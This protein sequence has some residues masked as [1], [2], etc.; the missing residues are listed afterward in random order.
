MPTN[1]VHTIKREAE[2]RR[3]RRRISSAEKR[4][5]LWFQKNRCIICGHNF[6]KSVWFKKGG[7]FRPITL[8]FDHFIPVSFCQNTETRNLYALCSLC[9]QIKW[10]YM[11]DTVIDARKYIMSVRE[12]RGYNEL[13]SDEE[14]QNVLK[15]ESF[16]PT[17][18][19]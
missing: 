17:E 13:Y 1:P 14:V 6:A 7:I 4:K 19:L 8:N 9:N 2:D 5:I 16:V 3:A 12:E 18:D 11:F 15:Q 10:S